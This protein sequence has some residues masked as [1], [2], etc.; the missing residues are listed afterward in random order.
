MPTKS[1]V[2][3][4]PGRLAKVRIGW[5]NSHWRY[6]NIVMYILVPQKENRTRQW[7]VCQFTNIRLQIK[8][9]RPTSRTIKPYFSRPTCLGIFFQLQR[10]ACSVGWSFFQIFLTNADFSTRYQVIQYPLD[11][12]SLYSKKSAYSLMNLS[13]IEKQWR[14]LKNHDIQPMVSD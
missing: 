12:Q 4:V 3:D 10:K 14:T 11:L 7:F 13:Y 6:G 9:F 8:M 5:W 1:F 2:E